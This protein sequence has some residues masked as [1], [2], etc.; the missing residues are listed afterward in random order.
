M[1]TTTG[2]ETALEEASTDLEGQ[3]QTDL[4]ALAARSE[5]SFAVTR[6]ARAKLRALRGPKRRVS[7]VEKDA[8]VAAFLRERFK[9]RMTLDGLHTAC[10][11]RFGA[12]RAPSAG[13]IGVFRQRMP[14]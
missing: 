1:A 6:E 14:R 11:E 2:S 13:R 3:A 10:V 9:S 5:A 7:T 8:E 12:E 4:K